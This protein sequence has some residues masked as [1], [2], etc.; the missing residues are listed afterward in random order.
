RTH[1]ERADAVDHVPARE[2]L[3]CEPLVD[4]GRAV[5]R[6]CVAVDAADVRV[7]QSVIGLRDRPTENLPQQL[8]YDLGRGR[9][10]RRAGVT[11]NDVS[12]APTVWTNDDLAFARADTLLQLRD[13]VRENTKEV[14][15]VGYDGNDPARI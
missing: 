11:T 2:A 9:S 6:D 8:D 10:I 4:F 1:T 15:G 13:Y 12:R 3:G 7:E 5:E 14:P